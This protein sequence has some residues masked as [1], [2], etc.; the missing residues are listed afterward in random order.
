MEKDVTLS[1]ALLTGSILEENGIQVVYT[2]TC[3]EVIWSSDNRD[4]LHT[5]VSIAKEAK[6]DYYISFHLNASNYN[7][8]AKGYE[9]YLN[10]TND[11]ITTMANEI[12]NAFDQLQFSF[13][14]GLKSTEESSLYVIDYNTI[15]AMLIE[16]GFLTDQ[17][18][19]TYI[20]STIGQESIAQALATSILS[21]LSY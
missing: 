12:L 9:I 17:E 20:T 2:R 16:F 7:D 21:S 19:T 10:Y 14:R 4:D 18:D 1:L 8:G 6:A 11:T 3:D 13:N 5:R 15:P